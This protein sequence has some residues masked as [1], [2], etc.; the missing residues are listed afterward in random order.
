MMTGYSIAFAPYL[1]VWSLLILAAVAILLFGWLLVRRMPGT[2]FRAGLAALLL[3]GLANPALLQERRELNP[4]VALLIVDETPSQS[5]VGRLKETRA[6]AEEVQEQLAKFA[7]SLEVRRVV[8]RH[9]TVQDSATGTRVVEATRDALADVPARRYAGAILI[10]DGQIHD[11][12][13]LASLPP[14]PLH[15]L[16]DGARNTPDRRLQIVKAPSFGVVDEPLELT[17]RISDPT[18]GPGETIRPTLLIDGVGQRIERLPFN[19][20]VT[21]TLSLDHRG[22]SIIELKVPELPGE[23][24]TVNNSAVLSINGVRDRLRVLLVSGEPH[25]GER[26]WRNLLKSD[27]SV[28][29]VHFTI[30]RPPEKQDGT[31]IDELS[32]IAFPTREL[33]EVKLNDFDLIVFDSY[34]RR[35]VLPTL[36]LGNIVDY[37]RNGG[38]LLDAA[39]PGFAGPF[40]LYRTPLGDILPLEPR[41]GVSEQAFKPQVTEKGLRHPVTA[42]L[43]D[44]PDQNAASSGPSWGDWLRQIDVTQRSGDVIMTGIGDQPLITLDR[45]GDGRVA[46]ISSDQIW[47][48]ARGYDG[49]GPHAELLRRLAHWLMKEPELEEE[50]LKAVASDDQLEIRM[51]TL[52]DLPQPP[53][54]NVVR[55]DGSTVDVPL[56]RVS[57]G[58]YAQ[59]IP[60]TQSGLFEIS[61]GGRTVR[62]AAGALNSL[63][64]ADLV[65]TDAI[66]KQPVADSGGRLHWLAD[67]PVP[68]VRR[69]AK[70]RPTGG[71]GWI[72]LVENKDYTVVGLDSVPMI[73]GWVLF[74]TAA[75]LMAMSWYREAR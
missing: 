32:L 62:T 52:E 57:E 35:G 4:D 46:Q 40:S 55:P 73:P 60:L 25:P 8:L 3:L 16:I 67:G 63:E 74:L 29:L 19:Q 20:D 61:Q 11:P 1:P 38:A 22:A 48:W 14:G 39:G 70:G 68:Q 23:L 37:V 31:P 44:G 69:V 34:R 13:E 7:P 10:T 2:L 50:D 15:A 66:L 17:L 45:V 12:Q 56:K 36:Y 51:R 42:G 41:G 47:L 18:V 53:T 59:A 43:P 24:S 49:G 33:F 65:A 64:F 21:V 27:P 72:G 30:L 58:L 54:A 9:N 75:G 71:S 6:A 28:D 5:A 26:T